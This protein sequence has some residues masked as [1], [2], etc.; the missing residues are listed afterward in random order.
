MPQI[1]GEREGRDR[2][3]FLPLATS[4][5]FRAHFDE[6][7]KALAPLKHWRNAEVK[8]TLITNGWKY[9]R[10]NINPR[11]DY[12]EVL[13]NV[14]RDSAEVGRDLGISKTHWDFAKQSFNFGTIWSS[15]ILH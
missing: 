4:A 12:T 9:L 3:Q 2:T 14:K 15:Q 1:D 7:V 13:K 11:W 8:G 5:Y 6:I 10:S